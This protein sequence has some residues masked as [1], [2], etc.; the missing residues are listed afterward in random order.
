MPSNP[1]KRRLYSL[2]VETSFAWGGGASLD[3]GV[4]ADVDMV[5]AQKLAL[6]GME[7]RHKHAYTY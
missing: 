7:A 6:G 2:Y 3:E 5:S 1:T 4:G